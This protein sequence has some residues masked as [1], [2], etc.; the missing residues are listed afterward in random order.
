MITVR[1]VDG[2][3]DLERW[4]QIRLTLVPYERAATIEEMRRSVKPD[5]LW[6]LAELDGE[7]A[8][9]GVAGPSNLTG[10]GFVVPRVLP[11]A[12]R[13]GLGTELLFRLAEHVQS[14]GFGLAKAEVD[15][16]EHIGFAER[17]GFAEV[18]RQVEQIRS[19]GDEPL[20]E[21]SELPAGIEIVSVAERPGI[22]PVVYDRVALEAFEDF[23]VSSPM[24]ATAEQWA[25]DWIGEPAAMFVALAGGE[26]IG[27]AGLLLD[28]DQPHRAEL[29]LTAV[30]REYRGRGIASTLK[31]WTHA[32]AARNGI[33]EVY[34]W[35]QRGNEN[36]QR[37]NLHLGYTTRTE[38]I[39]TRATLPLSR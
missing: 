18:D 5:Q 11:H 32:W 22:W 7:L 16:K 13:R 10:C 38:S 29:G 27:T 28:Q 19:I 4:R 31:R 25:N 9:S 1:V 33:T 14:I 26:P 17:Y 12:R 15:D 37:L 20:P 8:G 2:D 21:P 6:L 39:T 3:E 24:H 23:A 36:M 35:T 30:R 34:T